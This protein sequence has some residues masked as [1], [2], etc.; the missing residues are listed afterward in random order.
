MKRHQHWIPL[1]KKKLRR[2]FVRYLRKEIKL[3]FLLRIVCQPLCMP[4]E[5]MFWKK[6]KWLKPELMKVYFLKKVCTMPCGV[7]KLE[8]EKIYRRKLR[9]RNILHRGM[10]DILVSLR[11][12]KSRSASLRSPSR[13]IVCWHGLWQSDFKIIAT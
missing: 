11:E 3:L 6:V 5:F 2:P 1:R 10:E 4:T 8:K 7:S 12:N 9:C 13:G